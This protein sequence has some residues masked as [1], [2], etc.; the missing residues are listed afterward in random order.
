MKQKKSKGGIF[1]I[2]IILVSILLL[3]FINNTVIG[4][5]N[6]PTKSYITVT[7]NINDTLWDIA[8]Q[9]MNDNYYNLDE[10]IDEVIMINSIQETT[11]YAGEKLTLPIVE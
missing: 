5:S 11:I 6:I 2:S 4:A 9:Y 3:N 7:I 8:N 10:Y 1:F